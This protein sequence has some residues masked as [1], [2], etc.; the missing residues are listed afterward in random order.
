MGLTDTPIHGSAATSDSLVGPV[1]EATPNPPTHTNTVGDHTQ[2]CNPRHRPTHTFHDAVSTPRVHE[3][4]MPCGSPK[5]AI[6]PVFQHT[7]LDPNVRP[8]VEA[9]KGLGLG[10]GSNA[11]CVVLGSAHVGVSVWRSNIHRGRRATHQNLPPLLARAGGVECW[12]SA[13]ARRL[14]GHAGRVLSGL[15]SRQRPP[16]TCRSAWRV[17]QILKLLCVHRWA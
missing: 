14:R 2:G 1:H 5:R 13:V 16:P 10:L 6:I 15:R 9:R 11:A 4:C 12:S 8:N 17:H 7:T 3:P